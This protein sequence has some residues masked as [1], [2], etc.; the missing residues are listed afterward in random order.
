MNPVR[1]LWA[2]A[3]LSLLASTSSFAQAP[4]LS[5]TQTDA[6]SANGAGRATPGNN[7]TYTI[8]INNAAGAG[9]ATNT[10]INNPT[11]LNTTLGT[12]QTTCLAIN[13]TYPCTGN[14]SIS[15]PAGSGVLLND[16]DP[17]NVGP[18]ITATAIAGGATGQGG[19]VTLNADGSFTYNP[20]AGYTGADTFSYTL[21]DGEG[22]TDTAVVTIT[23][24]DM[25]WFINENAGTNGDGRLATPF[26]NLASFQAINDGIGNHPK[27][28]Q[29]IFL[30]ESADDYAGGITLLG[31]AGGGQRL[32]GQDATASL[33]TLAGITPATGSPALPAMNSGN[34]TV[35]RV[36]NSGGNGVTMGLNSRIHGFTAGN[37]SGT[38]IAAVSAGTIQVS[39]VVI[40]STGSALNVGTTSFGA[41]SA[42]TSITSSGG[43]N[44]I[45]LSNMSGTAT[46]GSGALSGH[47]SIS[48]SASSGSG[49]FSYGG[50]IS[51]TSGAGSAVSI[52][53]LTGTSSVSLSG[54]IS[55]TG[56][57]GVTMTGNSAGTTVNLT[58]GVFVSS[59]TNAAFTATGG[60]TINVTGATN[61]LASTTG[62]ALNVANTTIGASGLTFRS[63]SADGAVNGI[64]LNNTGTSGGLTVTGNGNTTQGGDNS[65]GTIQ[66]TTGDGISLTNTQ[67]ASFTNMRLMNITGASAQ[68]ISGSQITGSHLFRAG[69]MENVGGAA[70]GDGNGIT[71]VN[72]SVNMTLFSVENSIFANSTS[73]TSHVLLNPN[74]AVTVRLDV[75]DSVFEG[76]ESLA[77]Q[78]NSGGNAVVTTNITNNIFRNAGA[79]GQGGTAVTSA[80]GSAGSNTF[81][82]SGNTYFGLN[83]G[84]ADGANAGTA[85]FQTTGGL[86]QG[87][88]LNNTLG[89]AADN[90]GDRR[91]I[92]VVAEPDVSVNGNTGAI[93][94][95]IEGNIINRFT[96]REAIFVDLRED[97]LNSELIIRNNDIGN[98]AGFV[99]QVGGIREAIDVQVRGEATYKLD[100]LMTGNNV[101]VNSNIIG[102]NIEVN[103]DSGSPG[104][105]TFNAHITNNTITQS[106]TGTNLTARSRTSDPNVVL[107]LNFSGNNFEGAAG[108]LAIEE[109]SGD[110]NVQQASS[111]AVTSANNSVPVTILGTLDFGVATPPAP[112]GLLFT[113]VEPGQFEL[114]VPGAANSA[115]AWTEAVRQRNPASPAAQ[116]DPIQ[117]N[118][119]Q[120]VVPNTTT[121]VEPA[122]MALTQAQLDTLVSAALARWE[123][124][125]L[126]EA[127]RTALGKLTFEVVDLPGWYLGEAS[128]TTLRIDKDAGGNGWFID[129]TPSDDSEFSGIAG[130]GKSKVGIQM[131]DAAAKRVDLLTAVMHE[132]GHSL[133]LCDSYDPLRRRSLMYGFLTAGERRV[134]KS[135]E[136]EGAMPHTHD[137]PHYLGGDLVIGTLPPGKS[138]TIT[139]TATISNTPTTF[140]SVSSQGTV[141]ADD[142]DGGG[143]LLA[144]SVLT[145][146]T[147]V[148]GATDPTV[149]PVEQLP[150]VTAIAKSTTEDTTMNFTAA[151]FDAGFADVNAGDTL[152]TLRITSLPGSGTLFNNAV[153]ITAGSLP[154]DIARANIPLLTYQPASNDNGST[155]FSW[156][157]SDG[158]GFATSTALVNIT[159][160][161]VND[162]P[163]LTAIPNP[164]AI[165][166]DSGQQ[167]VN[168]TGIGEGAANESAQ[169]LTITASSDN[170]GLI[171]NPVT[172]NYTEGQT[173]GTVTYTPVANAHGTA[174]ITVTVQDSGGAPGDDTITRQFMVVVNPVADT[175]SITNATTL[176]NTQTTSGLVVSRNAVDGAEVTH[177]QITNIQNGSLFQ[178]NGTTA[179]AANSFITH[180]EASA[181]LKFTPALNFQGDATFQL[182]ASTS[183][184]VGG[185]GGNVVTATISVSERVSIDTPNAGDNDAAEGG[186]NNGIFTFTRGGSAGVLVANFQ[187]H[188]SST[189]S[190]ADFSLAVVGSGSVSFA[191]SSGTVSFPDSVTTVTVALTALA[192][193]PNAAEAAETVRFDVVPIPGTYL[194]G[195]PDNATVTIAQNGFVVTTTND[196]GSGSLRQAVANANSIAG[197]DTITFS[198]GTGGTVNFTDGVQDT[199]TLITGELPTITES[200]T[201]QGPVSPRVHISGNDA[202]PIFRVLPAAVTVVAIFDRLVLRNGFSTDNGAAIKATGMSDVLLRDCAFLN[203]V[204]T[205][206]AGAVLVQGELNVLRCEFSGNSATHGGAIYSDSAYLTVAQSTFVNNTAT[207]QGGAI[208]ANNFNPQTVEII[209]STFS[210]NSANSGGALYVERGNLCSIVQS[211]FTG[212]SAANGGGIVPEI[213]TPVVENTI[214]AGNTATVSG[215]EALGTF[216]SNG[217]NFVGVTTGATG[218]TSDKTFA[219]TGTV[220]AQ[221]IG[222]LADNGGPTLT[223]AL[224]AGSPA[225]NAGVT[226][227]LP[228][229]TFDLDGDTNTA[230]PIPFDQRG[231]GFIRAIG[232]VDIGAVELQKSV[233][234][235]ALDAVKAEGNSGTTNF[236]FT[237]SRTGDTT[238]DVTTTYTVGGAGVDGTDFTGGTLPTG[239]ATITTG[240][241]S[242]T[243]T[244]PVSGDTVRESN[245]S[246]TVTLSGPD[247]GYVVSGAPA[248]GTINNDDF[249]ADLSIT[250]T[251]GV[252]TAVPGGSVTYTITASNVG[253]DPA[254]ATVSDTFPAILTANWTAVGA[255]GGTV[256]ASGSGNINEAV[257][258]PVGGSVTFTV[259]ATI[260]PSAT[261][262]L[263]N[264]AT[265]SIGAGTS[266]PNPANNSA[267]D[268][269]TLTP[270]SDLSITKT[271][272]VSTAT[273][274]GSV[275]YTITVSNAG[276]SNAPGSTV[277]DTL[278]AALTGTWTGVGAGGGT[279]TASGSGNINDTVNLPVGGSFTYTLSA[280]IS[281]AATGNLSNTATAATAGGVV[282]PNAANNSATDTDTLVAQSDLSITK[283]DGVTTATPGGSVTYTITASN[284]GPSNTTATVADTFP[285]SFTGSWTAVGAGGGTATASGSGNINDT[286]NL[287]AGG[288]VTYTVTGSISPAATGVMSNT[289]TV[290]GVATDPVPANNSATDTDTLVPQ[291][292]LSITKTDG[293][294]TVTPGGGVTYTITASNAGPSNVTT[295][296]VA[297]TLPASLTGA[298]W[299]A[300]GAGGGTATPAGAGNI[301]DTV[302]LPVGGSVTYTVVATLAPAASGTLANTATVSSGVTDPVPANNSATDTDNINTVV[303]ITATDAD[304]DE[305]TPATATWRVSRTGSSGALLVNLLIDATGTATAADWTQTGA[306]F[307]TSEPGD[308]GTV[309]IPDGQGFV[310]IVLTPVDELVA[311]TD[312]TVIL[313]VTSSSA[314][315]IASVPAVNRTVTIARNDFGV[316]NTN[317]SGEGSLRLAIENANLLPG[318][319]TV[320]FIGA[321]FADAVPDLIT[322]GGTELVISEAVTVDGTGA[323]LLSISGNDASRIFSITDFAGSVTIR[324]LTLTDGHAVGVA[325]D[326]GSILKSGALSG[327][328]VERCHVTNNVSDSRG[329]GLFIG[330]G[331]VIVRDSTFSINEANGTTGGGGGIANAGNLSVLNSTISGNQAPNATGE[332]G[333][334]ILD[335]GTLSLLNS[336]VTGNRVNTTGGGGGIDSSGNETFGNSVVAGNFKGG[337]STPSDIE[338][339]AVETATFT[340]VGD[341]TT[342]GGITD[343]TSGNLVGDAGTGT[344][345][346]A[347]VLDTILA[348]NGGPTPTHKLVAGGPAVDAGDPAFDGSVFAPVMDF[349]QRGVGFVRI[350]KGLLASAAAVV[351]LGAFELIA[352]PV[353]TNSDLSLSVDDAP[354]NLATATGVSPTGGVFSGPGVS[355]GFFDPRT[356]VPGI[357]TLTYTVTDAFGVSNSS[358]FTVTVVALPSG[359]TLTQPK[360]F[361]TT[362]VGTSSRSQRVYIR[363][364]GGQPTKMVRV[365]VSGRGKKDFIVTQPA[366]RLLEAGES[367]FFQ[368]TFRPRAERN[369][370]ALVTVYSDST[371]VSVKLRGRGQAKSGIRP[372]R[373]V[374]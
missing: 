49:T 276:P 14:L 329:G 41:G 98:L 317:D 352:A 290:A 166:E 267:T 123:A 164:T 142:P 270:Q 242:T 354:L 284:A 251:D 52:T 204:C 8:T 238:G 374:K 167:T 51:K 106:G 102:V 273:P 44:G 115:V 257:T 12:I 262:T 133:G 137:A 308:A 86:L 209:Q 43:S 18:A 216:T 309:T 361:K 62:T 218:F 81:V 367:T 228:A 159:I 121:E 274:G 358:E 312:E 75:K 260:A 50:S 20:P 283:T 139:Y 183:N 221:V 92:E 285:A 255:G 222:S 124:T 40:N 295:A 205:F 127:Q 196:S 56:V 87:S 323:D 66:N 26:N 349:D 68:G 362:V 70:S 293:V 347:T 134:P 303:S 340:L 333:G 200:V 182:Q 299:S 286:V 245:E 163:T 266:D 93:D 319:D 210:G 79:N 226:G 61:T 19:T 353:F 83:N 74:G 186:V 359:L 280:T 234:I 287:P 223:H 185:L 198:D 99:G 304:A 23:V 11:P 77:V 335:L 105:Q 160:T 34:A 1:T 85:Q 246:F 5:A 211:T 169:T 370:K 348:D 351:D 39:D 261:G 230:E 334:G 90:N 15:I 158:N 332:G 250:K 195:T 243:V 220:L 320:T 58:G 112:A 72:T 269:D 271:D 371:P 281:P 194:A 111:A 129:E 305:I 96:D 152:Q 202:S 109:N 207:V 119:T 192:E 63:I 326:G 59:G 84:V 132:M 32:I 141:T 9:T 357:Y 38:A 151:N 343:G 147:A 170:V 55:A 101:T 217:G 149:T 313:E 311:E 346:I 294:T 179:I 130:N 191:G 272:G 128:G 17:D 360:R 324:D 171:P 227:D 237:L 212:N 28:G 157:A 107:N 125:G 341:S 206:P 197:P 165:P 208:L 113:P 114:D 31:A 289:A 46:L 3:T 263:S 154:L 162:E 181:G 21:N 108:S 249:E 337:G 153:A 30:Y 215:P 327:L 48:F 91:G 178:N 144:P 64:V 140:T 188:G 256:A 118:P 36:V 10:K 168:L 307:A 173:T 292:D 2:L 310:D 88:I 65:G 27:A 339:G 193:T 364:V 190:A 201:V 366:A 259:S 318:T 100:M 180:A 233:S 203:N 120:L 338:G 244:I 350:E 291:A 126:S 322:L 345:D 252:I 372:P 7:V 45:T 240:N 277:A 33:A 24:S 67:N 187:L 297:D 232:T 306:T 35:S 355:G 156:L 369:R 342:A 330:G 176:P 71:L 344:L 60:G 298:I 365:A 29:S 103:A 368:V 148:A 145:D 78:S 184:V 225:L 73:G 331:T 69:R 235:T 315:V 155:S 253:P 177:Y 80:A 97:C 117:P 82:V 53:N 316:T 258:L 268:T 300:V 122:A 356:Q 336:T 241:T 16:R 138:I 136:A 264:T 42:F 110:V 214:L 76:L 373:A 175:P 189:A 229:D 54:A 95:I 161:A 57:A 279:G 213:G 174:T 288:S 328:I 282:D 25:I 199:I 150:T 143:P 363:N 94:V 278:P 275:T 247:N 236:T 135:G 302:N 47:S 219:S 37:A 4:N 104:A 248:T 314:Y 116:S 6:F 131:S 231:A 22:N 172:V 325:A 301:N 296:T 239:N 254:T 13:D 89:T 146:D 224:V 321:T 265:V